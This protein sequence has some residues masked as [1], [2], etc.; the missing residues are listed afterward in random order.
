M[1]FMSIPDFDSSFTINHPEIDGELLLLLENMDWKEQELLSGSI[2]KE[3]EDCSK[4][5]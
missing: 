3:F 5:K 1:L 2:V 4:R